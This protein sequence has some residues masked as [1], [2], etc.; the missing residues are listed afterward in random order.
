MSNKIRIY[1]I[2]LQISWDHRAKGQMSAN[3]GAE[4]WNKTMVL[5]VEIEKPIASSKKNWVFSLP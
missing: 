1:S 4:C 5:F 3:G 2:L